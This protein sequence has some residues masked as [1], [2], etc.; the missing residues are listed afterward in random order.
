MT[1][2]QMIIDYVDVSGCKHVIPTIST[3]KCGINH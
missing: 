2:K 1:D 3:I